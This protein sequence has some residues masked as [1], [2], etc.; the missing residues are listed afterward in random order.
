MRLSGAKT[1]LHITEVNEIE[2]EMLKALGFLKSGESD[3]CEYWEYSINFSQ[4]NEVTY[5]EIGSNLILGSDGSVFI[6]LQNS[7]YMDKDKN[8]YRYDNNKLVPVLIRNN[9]LPEIPEFEITDAEYHDE[10]GKE[11][12]YWDYEVKIAD[13]RYVLIRVYDKAGLIYT[14]QNE[15]GSKIYDYDGNYFSESFDEEKVF[16]FVKEHYEKEEKGYE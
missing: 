7:S 8:E 14:V 5:Q 12:A 16:A 3:G 6:K 2:R 4:E 11:K 10:F 15:D 13:N 9:H 1:I